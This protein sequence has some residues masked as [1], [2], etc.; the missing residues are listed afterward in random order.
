MVRPLLVSSGH[1]LLALVKCQD[2]GF[3]VYFSKAHQENE[4]VE[5]SPTRSWPCLMQMPLYHQQQT[6]W[7]TL[8]RRVGRPHCQF[9]QFKEAK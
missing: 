4:V 1:G 7:Y 9:G 3:C 2:E 6:A 8:N 5:N